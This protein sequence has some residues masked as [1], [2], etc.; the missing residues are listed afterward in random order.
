MPSGDRLMARS[1]IECLRQAGHYVEVISHLRALVRDPN[2]AAASC[3]L[4]ENADKERERIA[5]VWKQQG[6]PDCWFCYHPYYKSP[7]LLGPALCAEFNLPYVTAEA[8]YSHRR[9]EGFWGFAQERVLEGVNAAAANLYFTQRD[10]RGLREGSQSAKLEQLRP[11]IHP[12]ETRAHQSD[13]QPLNLV[14]VAM[15]RSGDKWDSYVHLAAALAKIIDVPWTLH[16]VGDGPE[17]EAIKAL[18]DIIPAERLVWHGEKT[19]VQI[20]TIFENSALYVW[21]GCGE[22]Y[23]LAYLEAQ[24]VGLPVVAFNTAGVPEV[25]DN[26]YSGLLTE[27]ENDA[28]FASAIKRLLTNDE[29]RFRMAN[30]AREHVLTKHSFKQASE[31]LGKILQAVM[32]SPS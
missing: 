24:S 10:K 32:R 11:F 22:A 14:S 25:V 18:F 15:M 26:G 3:A 8:S 20:A 19:L 17:S 21:P 9:T 23:G 28:D 12:I 16:I 5:S 30:N 7:D 2:D 1:L 13:T 4:I 27:Q 29:E 31:S 6:A